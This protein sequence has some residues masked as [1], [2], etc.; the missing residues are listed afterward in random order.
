MSTTNQHIKIS[1]IYTKESN[2]EV[3]DAV[4]LLQEP[5]P[6][7]E[8]ELACQSSFTPI[9]FKEEES[10]VV[11]LSFQIESK[12]NNDYL[13][14]L[15]FV[16]SGIFTL[17]DYEGKEQLEEALAVDCPNIIFPYARLHAHQISNQTGFAP[18]LIQQINFKELYY[19]EIGKKYE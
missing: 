13:Y 17:Y 15:N 14:I 1:A 10:F 18:V 16:Q 6:E 8:T 3:P 4:V 12:Y 19:K 2:I 5:L 9:T 7:V 11:D